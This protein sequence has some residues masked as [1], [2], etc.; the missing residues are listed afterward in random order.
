MKVLFL[1]S[2]FED[3][4]SDGLLHGLRS[5]LGC[6]LVDFPKPERMYQGFRAPDEMPGRGFTL[7]G[8]LDDIE[9]DRR[10]VYFRIERRK[11]DLVIVGDVYRD[12]GM[13][14][15]ALPFLDPKKTA[16]LDGAD[17]QA[18]YPYGGKWWRHPQHWSLPRANRFVYFKR[19]LTPRSLHY[20][21]YLIVPEFL[22]RT[23]PTPRNWRR[24]AFSIPAEKVV[25]APPLKE[26]LLPA[27]IV[28]PEIARHVAGSSTTYPFAR[29]SDYYHDLQISRFGIT[30][31]RSG[32][33][34]LRHYELAAN[35]CVPCFRNLDQKPASCAPHGLTD[36]NCINYRNY[37]DLMSQ[38]EHMDNSRY[39]RLRKTALEWARRNSTVERA[40]Q[41][42][43]VYGLNGRQGSV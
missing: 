32:W 8:Q 16:L 23:L 29:E 25:S 22:C 2:S 36:E 9:V 38:I 40:T 18:T 42:L 4:L 6:D 30:M 3:Y 1:T 31:K 19:E 43:A 37:Q 27:H 26:K 7:Y 28:D 5:L 41:L 33:D 17:Q 10:D 11:F 34:C 35:G 15:Q 14:V 13:F 39:E 20:R 21:T 12:F 24:T